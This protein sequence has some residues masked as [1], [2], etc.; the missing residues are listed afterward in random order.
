M[1]ESQVQTLNLSQAHSAD[2]SAAVLIGYHSFDNCQRDEA[3][4][5]WVPVRTQ[6]VERSAGHESSEPA[7]HS[8]HDVLVVASSN[9]GTQQLEHIAVH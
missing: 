1:S 9:V 7:T 6:Q 2:S 8:F 5:S 4:Q 3:E